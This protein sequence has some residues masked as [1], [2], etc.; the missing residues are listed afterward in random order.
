MTNFLISG[1]SGNELYFY[2]PYEGICVKK[3]NPG[4]NRQEHTPILPDG[5]DA[6][7][8]YSD[9]RGIV[10]IIYTDSE[11]HLLYAVRK[12]GSWKKHILSS[13]ATDIFLSDIRIY[14]VKGR[15]NFLYSALYCGETLLVHCILGDHARPSTVSA[16]ETSHFF[17]YKEKVYYTNALGNLGY[18]SLSDE[19][20]SV[21]CPVAEDAHCCTLADLG[22]NELLL[23]TRNSRLFVNNREIL[24]DS[25]MENPVFVRG[26]DRSYIMWKSGGFIRYIATFNGGV[27]WS[28]PMRFMNTGISPS[29]YIAQ[30]G[31]SYNMYYGY[32]GTHEVTLLGA[33]DIFGTQN[34]QCGEIDALKKQLSQSRAEAMS[35]KK[36][37]ERLN[38]IISGML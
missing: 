20:P 4:N 16:L 10:H 32:P 24:Y 18:S 22:A 21:F 38:K 3:Q 2:K 26:N 13:L 28:E 25:V 33:P 15:L 5:Q 9:S 11:N 30:R 14:S 37:I 27:T 36:E 34:Q 31:N 35:A 19:A 7:C 1:D 29:I 12:N 23:Y 17:I 8:A 6:F